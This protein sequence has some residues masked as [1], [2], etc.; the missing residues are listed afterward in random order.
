LREGRRGELLKLAQNDQRARQARRSAAAKTTE[1]SDMFDTLRSGAQFCGA[2]RVARVLRRRELVAR[3]HSLEL[4]VPP[5]RVTPT[6]TELRIV[7]AEVVSDYLLGGLGEVDDS[8]GPAART[9]LL[10]RL[11]ARCPGFSTRDYRSA[12][13]VGLSGRARAQLAP[14]RR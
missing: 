9:L 7:A 1:L 11:L 5:A 12:L 3:A 14:A 13:S 8:F 2:P 10:E 4:H 6:K